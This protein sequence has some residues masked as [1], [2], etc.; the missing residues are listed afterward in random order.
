MADFKDDGEVFVLTDGGHERLVQQ[1]LVILRKNICLLAHWP[2]TVNT[3]FPTIER[4]LKSQIIDQT[5]L[6][7]LYERVERSAC[8][9]A[10]AIESTILRQYLRKEHEIALII[11]KVRS[12]FSQN[13][14]Y[15]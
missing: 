6:Q 8:V 12:I 1:F 7:P 13:A 15:F 11:C 2:C 4:S 10:I 5:N 3:E 9:L 14:T